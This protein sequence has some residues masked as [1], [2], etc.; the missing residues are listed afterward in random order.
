MLKRLHDIK[1][2][3]NDQ[4]GRLPSLVCPVSLCLFG[5]KCL[6]AV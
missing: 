6:Q 4:T 2:D 3:G 1:F 5:G